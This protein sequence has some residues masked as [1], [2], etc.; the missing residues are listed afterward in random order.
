MYVYVSKVFSFTTLKSKGKIV[1]YVNW[2]AG[3]D[4]VYYSN[5]TNPS[6]VLELWGHQDKPLF[7]MNITV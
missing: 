7:G 4:P 2:Q 5:V 3:T 1:T 6:L